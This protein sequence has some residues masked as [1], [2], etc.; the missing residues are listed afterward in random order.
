MDEQ[1]GPAEVDTAVSSTHSPRASWLRVALAVLLLWAA[2]VRIWYGSPDPDS[3]RF[4]DERFAVENIMGVL[5]QGDPK[6]RNGFH[7]SLSYLPQLAV[8]AASQRVARWT[9]WQTLE[10]LGP[11]GFT[12]TAYLLCRWTQAIFGVLSLWLLFLV[13]RRLFDEP[14]AVLAVA[15]VATMPWH[16][17]QSAVFKPDIQLVLT[18]L[19]AFLLSLR[20]V[21]APR[22]GRFLAAGGAIGLALSA[23]FNAGPIAIPLAVGGLTMARRNWRAVLWLGAAGCVALGTF[24]ALNPY[25][26][27]DPQIYTSDFSRTLTDYA[28]KGATRAGGS[29]LLQFVHFARSMLSSH[30]L[31]PVIGI[32]AILA[33]PLLAGSLLRRRTRDWRWLGRWMLLSYI[34]G[35][36]V[37]YAL[38]TANPTAHN[39]LPVAPFTALLAAWLLVAAWRSLRSRMP[40]LSARPVG[41]IPALVLGPWLLWTGTDYAYRNLIPSTAMAAGNHLKREMPHFNDRV[42]ISEAPIPGPNRRRGKARLAQLDVPRLSEVDPEI[43]DAADVELFLASRLDSRETSPFYAQRIRAAQG[44]Y[45]ER[46]P[47]RLFH[48]RG[49]ELVMLI[50]P[51]RPVQKAVR[52]QLR[53]IGTD[54]YEIHPPHGR[55]RWI[56]LRVMMPR[57]VR[58]G[59]MSLHIGGQAYAC[60]ENRIARDRWLWLCPRVRR[61]STL[62]IEVREVTGGLLPPHLEAD[63][64]GWARRRPEGKSGSGVRARRPA[65]TSSPEAQP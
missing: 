44:G 2:V 12:A 58:A 54:R 38:S 40:A 52:V 65:A 19:L 33:P 22:L 25:V 10:V 62:R 47:P 50:H 51:Y 20:A 18:L 14:T 32:A 23:K 6:P 61:V 37:L 17:R 64:M 45:F 31:G 16:I 35:Y 30:F 28:Y 9:G 59:S 55:G 60:V 36:S 42:V 63:V 27:L 4:W 46:F 11:R 13:G 15:L 49:P 34:A 53:R 56:S 1:T 29:H 21:E 39:W 7:P 57:K 24:L 26:V 48:V 41:A 3:S 43:L 8:L 5:T